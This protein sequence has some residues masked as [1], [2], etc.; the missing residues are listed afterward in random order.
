MKNLREIFHPSKITLSG[1]STIVDTESGKYVIK[2]KNKDIK[3]LFAYLDSRA[4]N[5]YPDIVDE[6]DNKLIYEYIDDINIPVNQKASDMA[7]LLSNLHYK[8]SHYIPIVKDDIKEI[9]E[10]IEGN[11]LYFENYYNRIYTLAENEEFMRPS[12]YLLIRNQSKINALIKF[13]K[14]ELEK[15]YKETINK[16]KTRV[17]YNHN[18]LSLDHYRNAKKDYFISWDNYKVDTPVL[19]LINLYHNDFTKYD[20]SNFLSSY[21]KKFSLLPE[22]KRLFFI[23][24]SL[25]KVTYFNDNEM[26]N[27]I[28]IGKFIDYINNTEKLIRPYYIE[29]NGSNY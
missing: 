12:Y 3:S 25:P 26:D 8:T 4:F 23:V 29:E 21:L 5:N 24:I 27:T 11:I 1:K 13:L 15:W 19:D 20:F 6:Y 22:E 16:E 10:N 2:D 18:N 14:D 7:N 28:A 9:Y 17:V